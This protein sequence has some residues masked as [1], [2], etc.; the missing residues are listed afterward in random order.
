MVFW[1]ITKNLKKVFETPWNNYIWLAELVK[2]TH[3]ISKQGCIPCSKKSKSKCCVK[4]LF[5]KVSI[6]SNVS[7]N[8]S[9]LFYS[10]STQRRTRGEL[11]GYLNTRRA[12]Q[13]HSRHSGTRRW[14]RHSSTQGT[15]ALRHLATG[16]FEEHLGI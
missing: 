9:D 16:V 13:W 3:L 2:V 8:V 5:W 11:K 15:W 10:Q 1:N 7:S 4:Y 12:L 14:L 6:S